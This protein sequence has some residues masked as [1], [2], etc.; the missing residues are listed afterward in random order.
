MIDLDAVCGDRPRRS[1]IVGSA[2]GPSDPKTEA[3][4][5]KAAERPPDP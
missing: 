5:R 3:Q 4:K 1:R 2:A